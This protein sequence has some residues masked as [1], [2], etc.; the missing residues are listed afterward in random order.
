MQ[1]KAFEKQAG[2]CLFFCSLKKSLLTNYF[3]QT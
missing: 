3:L 2:N 1:V